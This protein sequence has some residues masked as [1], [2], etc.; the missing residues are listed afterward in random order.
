MPSLAARLALACTVLSGL[1]VVAPS[2]ALANVCQEGP[3]L[4][5]KRRELI[6]RL[7]NLNKGNKKQQ[8]HPNVACKAFGELVSNGSSALKWMEANGD[9]C[10]V[11]ANLR[12]GMKADHERAT[13]I[14]AQ[15]CDAANKLAAMERRARQQQQSGGGGLLGGDGLTGPARLP[16]GAL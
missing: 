10:Q 8:V 15:A 4:L 12:E 3:E 9:W 1:V 2:P 13:K 7:N 11:P 6:E 14:R 16:Q 5:N